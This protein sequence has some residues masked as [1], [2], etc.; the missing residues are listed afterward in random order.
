MKLAEICH[1]YGRDGN[2]TGTIDMRMRKTARL[3]SQLRT[4]LRQSVLDAFIFMPGITTFFPFVF[5][6]TVVVDKKVYDANT[7]TAYYYCV[8]D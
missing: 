7:Q 4:L 8:S 2:R 6:S 3:A 1:A 5:Y